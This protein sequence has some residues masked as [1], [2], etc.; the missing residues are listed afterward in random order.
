MNNNFGNSYIYLLSWID[1]DKLDYDLLCANYN[2][3]Y[4]LE[5]KLDIIN[6]D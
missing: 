5:Q 4:L 2:A 1:M 6:W 3:I